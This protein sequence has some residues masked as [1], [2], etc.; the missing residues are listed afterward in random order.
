MRTLPPTFVATCALAAAPLFAP[1]AVADAG[2]QG[3]ANTRSAGVEP[4]ALD[5]PPGARAVGVPPLETDPRARRAVRGC[6]LDIDCRALE[7][8]REFELQAFPRP[9]ADSPWVERDDADGHNRARYFQTDGTRA[10]QVAD[11]PTELRPDLPWL[12]DLELPDLPVR[13]HER[14]ITYLEFYRDD[15][16]GRRIM[17]AWLEAKGRYADFVRRELR[18][19]GMPRDLVYL[20]MIE[21]AFDPT[22]YSRAGASGLWQFMPSAGRI[23]GL[24]QTS[25]IDERNDP[26]LSTRAGILYLRDLHHRFGDWHLAIA[27]YNAGYGGILQSISKYN[28][29][30]FWALLQ[31]ENALPWESRLYVPKI[32][33]TAIV[34]NNQEAF[35]FGDI[36]P[37][38]P[39][40]WDRV[41]VPQ[42]IGLDAIAQAAGADVSDIEKLNPQLRRDRTPPAEDEYVVRIPHGRAD[43]FAERFPQREGDWDGYDAYVVSHGERFEDIAT[44]H[45]ISYHRLLELNGLSSEAELRG[46]MVLVVPEVSEEEK[47]K[48]RE[49]AED[50]LYASGIPSGEAGDDYIVAIPDPDD[51]VDGKRRVFYRVVS[52]NTLAQVA[53][54]FGVSEANLAAWNGIEPGAHIQAR[55][56]L[57]V[58]VPPS[59][60]PESAQVRLLD[61]ERV[62]VVE[63]GSDAHLDK[64]EERMGRR[65]VRYEADTER[66]LREIGRRY[67]LTPRDLARINRIPYDTVLQ[68]GDEIII[69]EVQ[70]RDVSPRAEQQWRR[71]RR[72]GTPNR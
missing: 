9:D 5:A 69:Y 63:R 45:G 11:D 49:K 65:R 67:G 30:D 52:G 71:A 50:D 53:R 22:G 43:L 1:S 33:A 19:A 15:P 56:V 36:E 6:P 57:Q 41:A 17:S 3:D 38:E 61:P 60:E 21:S 54:S 37:E 29:N 10:P 46:G 39:L 27:A 31:Y 4:G 42:S 16:R 12:E 8:L 26:E 23:Y 18:E 34:G 20:V 13:W 7:G 59:F 58:W 70:D 24:E 2:G 66:S 55:M 14:I 44:T 48:N 47:E 68:P 25:W 32:L 64:A 28:T 35:G 72:S 51:E 62:A 40:R